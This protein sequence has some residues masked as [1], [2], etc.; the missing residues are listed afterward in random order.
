MLYHPEIP[1]NT[2]SIGRLTVGLEIPL[3]LVAPF[4]FDISERAVRRAGLDYWPSVDLRIHENEADFWVWAEGRTLRLFSS[5]GAAP[6]TE[7]PFAAGDVL[8]FGRESVGLPKE[9]VETYGAWRIPMSGP[10]RSLNLS[11]AV[12][13]VAYKAMEK[14]RPSLFS[15][16]F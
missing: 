12:S 15:G 6:F 5:H 11:N 3:H 16:A 4:S 8:I 7:A 14:V 10:I 13:V 2:G 1:Q 9:L